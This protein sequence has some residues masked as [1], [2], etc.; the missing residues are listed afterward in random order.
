[1]TG[2]VRLWASTR[3]PKATRRAPLSAETSK[4]VSNPG[5]WNQAPWGWRMAPMSASATRASSQNRSGF[6]K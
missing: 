3:A 1:M 4:A 5:T 2:T 6:T